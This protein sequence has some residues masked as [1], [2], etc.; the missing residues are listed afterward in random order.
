M[1]S[2]QKELNWQKHMQI[3]KINKTKTQ[4]DNKNPRSTFVLSLKNFQAS[5]VCNN[6]AL[7]LSHII[8]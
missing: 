7:S 2:S 6:Q 4:Q 1:N 3:N 8:Y 5:L